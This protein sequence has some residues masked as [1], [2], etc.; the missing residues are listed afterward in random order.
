MLDRG[1][2]ALDARARRALFVQTHANAFAAEPLLTELALDLDLAQPFALDVRQL[3]ILEHEVDQLIQADLGLVVVDAGPIAGL[4]AAFAVLCLDRLHGRA[5]VRR[6]RPGR[7][8]GAF[9]P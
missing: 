3:Q 1:F 8:P 5:W 9:S 4:L 6:R 7:L 2:L